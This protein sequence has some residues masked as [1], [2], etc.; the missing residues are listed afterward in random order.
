MA[1]VPYVDASASSQTAELTELFAGIV[2]LRG[3][4]HN[5]HRALANQPAALRAFMGMSRYVRDDSRLDPRLRELA[6]LATGYALDVAYE[7]HHHV[8]MARRVGL[9][10]TK[11]EAFPRWWDS[12]VFDALERAVLSYADQV[13]RRRDVDDETF[14]TLRRHFDDASIVDLA[15]TVGWYHLCAAI[16]VPLRIGIEEEQ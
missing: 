4:V 7:Q 6:I 13:A 14:A 16:L 11:I 1:R 9:S 8:R 3:S 5:L 2:D 12:D 15:M 10:E